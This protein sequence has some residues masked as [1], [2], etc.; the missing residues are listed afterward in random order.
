MVNF[1]IVI[2][3]ALVLEHIILMFLFL[4]GRTYTIPVAVFRLTGN[5]ERP[6]LFLTKAKKID[7]H[8]VPRLRVKGYKHEFRDYLSENY[9]PSIRSKWGGL[10]LWEFEDQLLTPV[11]PRKI[12]RKLTKEQ[13]V[14]ID[15]VIKKLNSLTGVTFSYDKFLHHELKLKA[16]DD[17]DTEFMLQ[18]QARID[19][20]YAGGWKDF[21]MKYSGH[22]TVI[23]IAILMLVGLVLWFDK[24]PELASECYG[25]AQASFNQMLLEQ[26][27]EKLV[28]PA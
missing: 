10:V 27:S 4:W 3:V 21:L 1:G 8:G 11:I 24:L 14:K 26:A 9:Y 7:R 15:G 6:T 20:Q 25:Q 22:I 28:P 5:K 2:L 17:V 19:G 12:E 23:I 13:R 16:V 18:D